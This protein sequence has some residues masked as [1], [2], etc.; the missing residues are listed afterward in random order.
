E[1]YAEVCAYLTTNRYFELPNYDKT[2]IN[3]TSIFCFTIFIGMCFIGV[4]I[5]RRSD[6]KFGYNDDDE[7][8]K[9]LSEETISTATALLSKTP[10]NSIIHS[11]KQ[12]T[13]S[14]RHR[15]HFESLDEC[16]HLHNSERM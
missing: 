11:S 10:R 4:G 2:L 16:N 5:I 13:S 12:T 6:W 14:V 7:P 8:E 9:H 15:V 1:M 3:F